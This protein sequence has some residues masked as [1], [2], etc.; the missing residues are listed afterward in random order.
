MRFIWTTAITDPA[1]IRSLTAPV[2]C[3]HAQALGP[4]DIENK[5]EPLCE[6]PESANP[7][8]PPGNPAPSM[9][10]PARSMAE[11]RDQG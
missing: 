9:R 8:L 1:C 3:V 6:L 2:L 4:E 10:G 5:R 7:L 11:F